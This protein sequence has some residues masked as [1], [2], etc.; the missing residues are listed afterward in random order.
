MLPDIPGKCGELSTTQIYVNALAKYGLD[1]NGFHF[2]WTGAKIYD[3]DHGVLAI[4]H[5]A[6]GMDP[7]DFTRRTILAIKKAHKVIKKAH[8][9]IK[10]RAECSEH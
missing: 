1:V 5:T 6:T 10:R 9:V 8:K 2:H 7:I 4:H 3:N